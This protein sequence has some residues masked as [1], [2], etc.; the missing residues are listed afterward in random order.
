MNMYPYQYFTLVM[1]VDPT[2]Y[3]P[4]D[5]FN[6]IDDA[7]IDFGMYINDWS[8]AVDAEYGSYI[9][10]FVIYETVQGEY[11]NTS[12]PVVYYSYAEPY[13]QWDPVHITHPDIYAIERDSNYA[14]NVV[15]LAHTHAGVGSGMNSEAIQQYINTDPELINN[16]ADDKN[17]YS[18]D[19]KDNAKKT[20]LLN[21][22][23]TPTGQLKVYDPNAWIFKERNITYDMPYDPILNFIGYFY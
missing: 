20:G 21:Y 6:S 10:S 16:I 4:G 19:D 5:W 22:L 7:A 18:D 14:I 8:I 12:I 13:T 3:A 9:Y 17:I 2:G 1:F 23:V 15:A 11:G